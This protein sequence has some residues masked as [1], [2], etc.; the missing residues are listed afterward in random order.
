MTNQ[1]FFP[2]GETRIPKPGVLLSH[3]S[4]SSV[5]GFMLA[6]KRSVRLAFGID[7]PLWNQIFSPLLCT[8]GIWFQSG[9]NKTKLEET[10]KENHIEH[11]GTIRTQYS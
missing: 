11:N 1:V 9:S 6:I 8:H 3:H 7:P 4:T 10:I 5:P 2:F